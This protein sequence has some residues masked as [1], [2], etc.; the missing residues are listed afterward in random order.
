LE[1]QDKQDGI[2]SPVL[3]TFNLS[4]VV[5]WW[6]NPLL[7]KRRK[8]N[9]WSFGSV[10]LVPESTTL[11]TTDSLHDW[12]RSVLWYRA[13]RTWRYIVEWNITTWWN[14]SFM[15]SFSGSWFML[16]WINYQAY[17]WTRVLQSVRT[18]TT[19]WTFFEPEES[20]YRTCLYLRTWQ[21]F[22]LQVT[23]LWWTDSGW[24]NTWRSINAQWKL[25]VMFISDDYV[26]WQTLK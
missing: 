12:Y 23:V 8:P 11:R 4:L 9:Q 14:N 24:V 20:N 5:N 7:V 2:T 26:I 17:P 15:G 16:S 22:L 19:S 13:L 6:S 3:S 25:K 18:L 21:Y 1:E 10:D